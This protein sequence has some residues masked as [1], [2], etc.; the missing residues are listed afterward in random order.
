MELLVQITSGRGPVE[1]C[2]A[3]ALLAKEICVEAAT[4][5]LFAAVIEEEAGPSPATMQSA[6]L[7]IDGEG[8]EKFVSSWEGS[9]QWICPSPFRLGHRRKNWFVGVQSLPI[10]KPEQFLQQDLKF[11]TCK[12]GGPGGQH[13]NTTESAVKA[14]HVPTGLSAISRDERSQTANRKRA[15]ARLAILIA[16]HEQRQQAVNQKQRWTAHNELERGCA[17]RTYEGEDFKRV[18]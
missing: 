10:R 18:R 17:V 6:L 8:S 14:I 11:E 1:C 9:I 5:G 15:T 13:V 2:R 16:R 3:V 12:A 4:V 7:H